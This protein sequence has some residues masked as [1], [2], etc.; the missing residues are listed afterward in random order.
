VQHLGYLEFGELAPVAQRTLDQP[1]IF[2]NNLAIRRA[3]A[4][5]TIALDL[6][7]SANRRRGRLMV[8]ASIRRAI[9][10]SISIF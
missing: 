3:T 4:V 2:V 1:Q 7:S 9:S 5:W 6:V 10:R 8:H